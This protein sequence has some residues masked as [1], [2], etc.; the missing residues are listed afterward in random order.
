MIGKRL[1]SVLR[2]SLNCVCMYVCMYVYICVCIWL[3]CRSWWRNVGEYHSTVYVRTYVCMY[4]YIY[5][6]IYVCIWLNCSSWWRNVGECPLSVYVCMYVYVWVDVYVMANLSWSV[7]VC[8]YVS[9]HYVEVFACNTLTYT[10]IHINF[11][12]WIYLC[13]FPC[14]L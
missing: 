4:V 9:S 14:S 2:I 5:I 6:C 12:V 1:V 7:L 10:Y 13:I 8:L 3:N 11:R